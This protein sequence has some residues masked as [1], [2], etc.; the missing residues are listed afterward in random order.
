MR[1]AAERVDDAGPGQLEHP[2][3]AGIV[4]Q[5]SGGRSRQRARLRQAPRALDEIGCQVALRVG[6]A[7]EIARASASSRA[8]SS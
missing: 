8:G 2:F 6:D 5:E 7:S 3:A 4:G 1:V